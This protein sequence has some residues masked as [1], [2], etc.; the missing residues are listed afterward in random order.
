MPPPQLAPFPAWVTTP[1]TTEYAPK[2]EEECA[3][4]ALVALLEGVPVDTLR[5]QG[6]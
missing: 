5:V 1:T 4:S 6:V 2:S 3:P